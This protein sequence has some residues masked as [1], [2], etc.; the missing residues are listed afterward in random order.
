MRRL[1]VLVA[2]AA[3]CAAS[4]ASSPNSPDLS[5]GK[6]EEATLFP[7]CTQQCGFHVCF[8]GIANCIDSTW[9][10][11]CTSAVACSVPGDGGAHD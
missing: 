10:C 7:S 8:V 3:G 2:L 4:T 1:I 11:D 9:K 6:C 5:M